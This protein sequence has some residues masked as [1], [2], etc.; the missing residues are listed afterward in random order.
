MKKLVLLLMMVIMA[1]TVYAAQDPIG[2]GGG[3]VTTIEKEN[4]NT[5]IAELY[6]KTGALYTS[7][8]TITMGTPA[9]GATNTTSSTITVTDRNGSA[10]AALHNLE[11]WVSDDADGN[12]LTAT[13]ASG[14]LTASTG[15]IL[16]ALT[17]KKHIIA[18]TS[19]TGVLVL[20]L[21]DSAK[22]QG[23]RFVCKNPTTGQ[24]TVGAATVTASYGA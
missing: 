15:T 1:S 18:T 20:V 6:T 24:I 3:V 2:T 19:A 4:L 21:V 7:G 22:T 10:V 23:E 14:A 16:T 5:D 9:A 17:A 13:A 12:G 11:C 8:K